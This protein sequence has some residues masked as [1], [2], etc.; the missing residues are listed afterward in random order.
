VADGVALGML[1]PEVLGRSHQPLGNV[2]A[3]AA[4][5]RVVAGGADFMVRPHD[6][7]ADLGV[8]VLAAARHGLANLQVVLVPS[9]DGSHRFSTTVPKSEAR[10]ERYLQLFCPGESLTIAKPLFYTGGTTAEKISMYTLVM[11]VH[12]LVCVF[13]I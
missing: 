12:V 9:G 5:K 6:D 10:F 4:R 7:A 3:D 11:I 13:L 8:G 1:D 2:V